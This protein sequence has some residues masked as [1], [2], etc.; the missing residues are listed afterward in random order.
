MTAPYG[1]TSP[2]AGAPAVVFWDNWGT[3][4]RS[5][6]KE[7]VL[8]LQSILGYKRE[9]IDL[10]NISSVDETF[11]NTCLTTDVPSPVDQQSQDEVG[12][13]HAV[14]RT[15]GLPVTPDMMHHFKE[16]TRR[17]RQCA[18]TYIDAMVVLRELVRRGYLNGMISNAWGFPV[19]TLFHEA[20]LGDLIPEQT[21]FFSF[22]EGFAK[23]D[24]RLF[25]RACE[26]LGVKPEDCWMIGDSLE[27]DILPARAIGMRTVLLDREHRYARENVP[28]DV[29]LIDDPQ[30][31]LNFLP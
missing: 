19:K 24:R 15:Y 3:L 10:A 31:I 9:T 26:K 28:A 2:K 22:R 20:S 18:L 1:T 27:N 16:V 21:R 30:D 4:A 11:L 17:E 12:F 13:I 6:Y 5:D 14:G 29:L 23:P 7:P 25:I 8:K